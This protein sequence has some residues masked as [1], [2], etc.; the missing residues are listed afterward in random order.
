[1]FSRFRAFCSLQWEDLSD[2]GKKMAFIAIFGM[3]LITGM[4]FE[5]LILTMRQ[6]V[7]GF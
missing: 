7:G 2:R 6:I 5:R 4:I 1:M 3:G